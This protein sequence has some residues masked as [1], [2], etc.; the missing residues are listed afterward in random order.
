V[1][2][3]LG[4]QPQRVG[5]ESIIVKGAKAVIASE[6]PTEQ[7]NKLPQEVQNRIYIEA[8]NRSAAEMAKPPQQKGIFGVGYGESPFAQY[9]IKRD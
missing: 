5:G 3:E 7:W 8:L 2:R 4:T 6:F 1:A 9:S